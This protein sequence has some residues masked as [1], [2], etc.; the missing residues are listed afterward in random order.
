MCV[1]HINSGRH[2]S[3]SIKQ[4]LKKNL[5][6]YIKKKN[7][8][9]LVRVSIAV[10]KYYDQKNKL[11]RKGFIQHTLPYHCSSSKEVKTGTQTGQEPGTGADAEAR[12]DA[13]GPRT[14]S[15]GMAPPTMAGW[16]LPHQS[17]ILKMHYSWILWRVFTLEV[18]SFHMTV[19]CM[20][21]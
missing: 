16:P 15:L 17:L 5:V 4:N 11:G 7:I 12:K 19:A 10:T 6:L 18:P 1:V 13:A 2:T 8:F 9:I 14:I 20:S 3:I 21:S